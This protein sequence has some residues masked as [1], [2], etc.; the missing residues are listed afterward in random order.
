MYIEIFKRIFKFV[1]IKEKL[2]ENY[3]LFINE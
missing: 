2:N 1:W 3:K